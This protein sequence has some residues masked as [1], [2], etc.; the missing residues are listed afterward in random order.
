M[1][2]NLQISDKIN[3]EP[4][5]TRREKRNLTRL[6]E[7]TQYLFDNDKNLTKTLNLTKNAREQLIARIQETFESIEE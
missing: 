6:F 2:V 5:L 7:F 1:S 4:D 3:E